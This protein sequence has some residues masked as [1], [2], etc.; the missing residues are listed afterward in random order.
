[1]VS[2]CKFSLLHIKLPQVLAYDTFWLKKIHI[3]YCQLK[4]LDIRH[5]SFFFTFDKN[6]K[7]SKKSLILIKLKTYRY[8]KL[9]KL[10]YFIP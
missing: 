1:M 5:A 6:T 2:T 7:I 9:K 10:T 8:N 3:T 4:F